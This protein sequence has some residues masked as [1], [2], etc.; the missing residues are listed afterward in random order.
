MGVGTS[1][2]RILVNEEHTLVNP[3]RCGLDP[4]LGVMMLRSVL[5]ELLIGGDKLASGERFASAR[6]H[7]DA[8][9]ASSSTAE[10]TRPAKNRG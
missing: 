6:V 2:L 9:G 1:A 3:V 4:R 8:H 7:D 10:P 5:C